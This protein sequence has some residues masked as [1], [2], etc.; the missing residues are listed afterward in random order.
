MQQKAQPNIDGCM[1]EEKARSTKFGGKDED[2]GVSG[3]KSFVFLGT[4][5]KKSLLVIVRSPPEIALFD[6][7]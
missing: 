7:K 4:V 5:R 6:P 1:K 2:L 3:Q